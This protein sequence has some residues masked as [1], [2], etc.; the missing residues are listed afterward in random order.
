[1]SCDIQAI[2]TTVTSC[3]LNDKQEGW[4]TLYDK[5]KHSS[6]RQN[7]RRLR[8][9]WYGD[10]NLT[11]SQ[12]NAYIQPSMASCSDSLRVEGCLHQTRLKCAQI[13]LTFVCKLARW[14]DLNKAQKEFC[15]QAFL[16]IVYIGTCAYKNDFLKLIKIILS[17]IP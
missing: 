17:K 13:L 9:I 15:R 5:H 7:M 12:E 8:A 11:L 3:H 2:N 1:M 14:V 16:F 10:W 4:K 6:Q